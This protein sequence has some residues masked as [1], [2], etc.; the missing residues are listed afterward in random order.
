MSQ[1]GVASLALRLV[2][3][4]WKATHLGVAFMLPSTCGRSD[5]P[6]AWLPSDATL[7]IFSGPPMPIELSF[8]PALPRGRVQTKMSRWP[9]VSPAAMFEASE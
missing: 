1:S 3:C 7:A 8:S 2:A 9:L 5:G 6:F 4:D